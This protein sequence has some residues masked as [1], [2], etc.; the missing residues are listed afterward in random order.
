VFLE[1]QYN[2]KSRA[3]VGRE[4]SPPVTGQRVGQIIATATLKIRRHVK[5]RGRLVGEVPTEGG[6]DDG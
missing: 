6:E 2:E 1:V 4:L 5:S 3:A